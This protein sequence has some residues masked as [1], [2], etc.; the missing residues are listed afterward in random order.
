LI[1]DMES[2]G[3]GGPSK[4]TLYFRLI[5]R[6]RWL[7]L[8]RFPPTEVLGCFGKISGEQKLLTI[9]WRDSLSNFPN[10]ND[11]QVLMTHVSQ[12]IFTPVW[13]QWAACPSLKIC[14]HEEKQ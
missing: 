5:E 14:A 11:H 8:T 2:S 7:K 4:F 3:C 10:T 12:L 9:W 1:Y 6:G 13:N